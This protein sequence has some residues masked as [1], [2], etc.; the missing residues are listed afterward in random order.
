M[1]EDTYIIDNKSKLLK[2][3]FKKYAMNSETA[4]VATGYFYLNG[5]QLVSDS[6]QNLEKM[7]LVIGNEITLNLSHKEHESY[8]KYI[9][10]NMFDDLTNI[11]DESLRTKIKELY[12]ILKSDKVEV[13][14][15]NKG[16]LHSKAYLFLGSEKKAI[17]GSS[18]FTK[19]GFQENIELNII[20][21]RNE[22]VDELTTWF[23]EIWENE[24]EPFRE[25]MIK[26]IESSG[27][28]DEKFVNWGTYLPPK[29]LFKVLA[30]EILDGRID[31]A[32]EKQI[33]TLFQDIG[34]LNAENKMSKYY[35]CVVADSVGLGKSFIGAEIIK[36]FLYGKI[37]FWNTKLNQKWEEKGRGTLLVVPAHLKTQWRDDVLL[38]T[39]FTNCIIK[40]IDG[41]FHF[42]LID[43]NLGEL[44][45][46]KIV[47]DAKFS[48]ESKEVLQKMTDQF[49]LILVDEAHRFRNDDTNAWN[50]IQLLKKKVSYE[51]KS[52]N[53]VEEGIR[54][55]FILLTATPLNNRISD[56]INIFKVFIDRDL[57]D[58]TRQGKNIKLFE[59]YESIKKELKTSP[60]SS[61]L[62]RQLKETIHKIKN[63][64][65]DD[66]MILRTR[67]YI[68]D[69]ARYQGTEIGGKP[70]IFRDPHVKKVQYDK[71]L[72][73]YYDH[74]LDLYNGL[75]EFLDE[76][77]YP[78]VDLFLMED[79]RKLNIRTLMKILLLKRIESSIFAF[80]NSIKN[81]EAKEK[82]FIKL[83]E[84]TSDFNE[85]REKWQEKY[86]K[87]K[88][89]FDPDEELGIIVSEETED[90]DETIKFNIN[91]LK[92]KAQND[93][94]LIRKFRQKI[95]KI[96]LDS[97]KYADPKL[98][99][100]KLELENIYGN[101]G[102]IPKIIL[103]TQFKDTAN[104]IFREV[105]EWVSK[106][107]NVKL[108]NL[109]IEI[110]TGD[111]DI[112][113]KERRLNRFAPIA[114]DYYSQLTESEEL[115]FLVS[116]DAL[117]EGINIQDASTVINYDLPWNPMRIV[118]RVGRVNR[119]GSVNE[120]YVYNFFPD[121]DL[122]ELLKLLKRLGDKIEDVQNL[123]AKEMQILSDEED[124]TVDTIGETIK[125]EREQT[126]ITE[127]ESNLRSSDFKEAD[128]Y[129]EDPETLQKLKIIDK[130][131]EMRIS[132][133]QFSDIDYFSKK[134]HFY[135]VI[136]DKKI[137]RLYR[138]NDKKRHEKMKNFLV[139]FDGEN[140]DTVPF[141]E[142]LNLA[143]IEKG[144]NINELSFDEIKSLKKLVLGCEEFFEENPYKNYCKMFSPVQQGHLQQLSGIHLKIVNHLRHLTS[145]RLIEIAENERNRI[146]RLIDIY[147]SMNLRSN[148]VKELK[149]W[150]AEEGMDLATVNLSDQ[151][152]I[153]IIEILEDFFQN[154]LSKKP[155]TYFGGI[156]IDRDLEYK[157]VGWQS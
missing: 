29:E 36:D 14:I 150:F 147:S 101:G 27:V 104:Y 21:E 155:D 57:R 2:D 153:K 37:D 25:D 33:L 157:V 107:T 84:K 99:Q 19:P 110:I 130:I 11:E 126:D 79:T 76:L 73:P 125:K 70:L 89:D 124:V 80:E 112:E 129:G 128:V 117:S 77:E 156:R 88:I 26:L 68:R 5:Y 9:K 132:G 154:Y 152:P 20:E 143:E 23:D 17:V 54:N 113:T 131:K 148:E 67:K 100:L 60:G 47:S 115:H 81:M 69:A 78:Y 134:G 93:L 39:F 30:Y 83:L 65:L 111:V 4:K 40:P 136:G 61:D 50:N 145:S 1:E 137:L 108:R 49:D 96:K 75:A 42:K 6:V 92:Q 133:D 32:K 120:I 106:S 97:D 13:R 41:E 141:D 51:E 31:I 18:N 149:T 24:T 34:V 114:N 53:D 35:G 121:R 91:E 94:K 85:I 151:D 119:I 140:G 63:E 43:Q 74:Y 139:S 64:I 10:D 48:R 28:L 103:F 87:R 7:Q 46:I 3:Y 15:Y 123:L 82:Y 58:L 144:K 118:Q 38:K 66:L 22:Q 45:N 142:I 62:K 59:K 71:D 72:E 127:L 16:N 86:G 135:T 98:K 52:E 55:R 105:N 8:K 116:T 95:D 12:D 109:G 56:L 122:E 102:D 138:V 44:G 146:L 90:S